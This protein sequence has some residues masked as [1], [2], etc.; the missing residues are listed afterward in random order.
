MGTNRR[1]NVLMGL[2][3]AFMAV[4]VGCCIYIHGGSQAKAHRQDRLASAIRPNASLGIRTDFGSIAVTGMD[5]NEC[6]VTAEVTAHAP[7]EE[8]AQQILDK[9]KVVLEPAAEGLM[10]RVDKP[11]LG[12]NRSVGV[13]FTVTV[14]RHTALDCHT[15]FGSIRVQDIASA[16]TA[17]TS[18]ASVTA[19]RVSG[20]LRLTTSHGGIRGDQISSDG[21][22]A[23][24]SFGSIELTFAPNENNTPDHGSLDLRTSYGSITCHQVA[25]G[26]VYARTSFGSIHMYCLSSAPSD[27]QLDAAT[28]HGHITCQIPSGYA[29][30]VDLD[31]S[32]GKIHTERPIL[33]QGKLGQDHLS[34]TMGEGK[35]RLSLKTEFGN[36]TLR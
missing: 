7:T 3:L 11:S 16:V 6:R 5:T 2:G 22:V 32:F 29:G 20:P 15:S 21:I 24:S 19:D 9:V 28:S 8:E 13:S 10:L 1:F 35:G 33:V 14:P 36:I 18:F 31:T 26:Q 25:H 34:G 12:G 17:H 4:G 27:M 23:E 30:Q